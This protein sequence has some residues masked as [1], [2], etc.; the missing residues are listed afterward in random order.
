MR[1]VDEQGGSN[2]GQGSVGCVEEGVGGLIVLWAYPIALQH[3]PQCLCDVEVWRVRREIEEEKSPAFPNG[4]HFLD[5]TTAVDAG[6]VK[7]DDGVSC[8]GAEGQRIVA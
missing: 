7:H 2:G 8:P 4:P 1:M 5:E 3:S 6:I